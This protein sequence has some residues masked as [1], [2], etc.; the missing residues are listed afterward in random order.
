[1]ILAHAAAVVLLL[2]LVVLS[3]ADVLDVMFAGGA[4]P[5]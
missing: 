4:V 5:F 3:G 1:M 2:V